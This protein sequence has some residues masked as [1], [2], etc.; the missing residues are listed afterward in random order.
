MRH[1][2]K[3]V[4]TEQ[5]RSIRAEF[6]G[7]PTFKVQRNEGEP[8]EVDGVL[9]EI[10]GEPSDWRYVWSQRKKCFQKEDVIHSIKWI[11]FLRLKNRLW[12]QNLKILV[13]LAKAILAEWWGQMPIWSRF[14]KKCEKR[15]WRKESRR[16]FQ[17]KI[18]LGSLC[19]CLGRP[20]LDSNLLSQCPA[21][22][23]GNSSSGYSL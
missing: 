16:V 22:S 15:N 6:G 8:K 19:S 12:I 10:A 11:K 20:Q 23:L 1:P 13:T 2:R 3:F 14:K 7:S 9:L 5:R 21:V 4:W 17:G 18:V